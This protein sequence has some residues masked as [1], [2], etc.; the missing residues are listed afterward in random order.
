MAQPHSGSLDS[1]LNG[2]ESQMGRPKLTI[3]SGQLGWSLE[4]MTVGKTQ[5]RSQGTASVGQGSMC[6][7]QMAQRYSPAGGRG[8][9][10]GR[11]ASIAVQAPV[12]SGVG[13]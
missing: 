11:D 8:Q 3:G 1:K 5:V 2:Q 6:P 7:P 10:R 9:G 4:T 12:H 13:I